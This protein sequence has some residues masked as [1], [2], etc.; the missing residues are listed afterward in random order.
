MY[1]QDDS[2]F[3]FRIREQ[4]V[5][6]VNFDICKNRPKLNGYHCNVPW[7]SE[8]SRFDTMPV[9]DANGETD[10]Q[11]DRHRPTASN[12]PLKCSLHCRPCSRKRRFSVCGRRPVGLISVIRGDLSVD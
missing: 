8:F 12:A 11:T 6:T 4:R 10:R 3:R 1:P 2:A 9:G 7:D 5:T